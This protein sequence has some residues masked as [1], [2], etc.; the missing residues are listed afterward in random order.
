MKFLANSKGFAVIRYRLINAPGLRVNITE[1]HERYC[2]ITAKLSA[3]RIN[4]NHFLNQRELP[5]IVLKC[6]GGFTQF[7]EQVA[8]KTVTLNQH[9]TQVCV[10]WVSRHQ[11]LAHF[12]PATLQL[13]R[14]LRV[15]CLL[16]SPPQK[17]VG[18]RKCTRRP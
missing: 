14:T 18:D 4:H 16:S 6:L 1:L 8:D 10:K 2:L 11:R 17:F 15:S 3:G 9:Q 12:Q 5:A 7:K 13:E